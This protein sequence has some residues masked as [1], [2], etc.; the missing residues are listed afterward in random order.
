MAICC[1]WLKPFSSLV[2]GEVPWLSSAFSSYGLPASVVL[3]ALAFLVL[4]VAIMLEVCRPTS[5][6]KTEVVYWGISPTWSGT[7]PCT[8][9]CC[10]SLLCHSHE[11]QLGHWS[12]PLCIHSQGV[13]G[14]FWRPDVCPPPPWC[15][16]TGPEHWGGFLCS[17]ELRRPTWRS[18]DGTTRPGCCRAAGVQTSSLEE[19]VFGRSLWC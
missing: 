3:N 16:S 2:L 19:G 5:E 11:P 4:L 9:A 8:G 1:G 17:L 13:N 14:C 12:A 7:F 18:S 6:Y 10:P 15:V